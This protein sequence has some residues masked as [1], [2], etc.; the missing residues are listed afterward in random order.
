MVKACITA[1]SDVYWCSIKGSVV[2]V[3]RLQTKPLRAAF[4]PSP[5]PGH[6][7]APPDFVGEGMTHVSKSQSLGSWKALL[8]DPHLSL[9]FGRPGRLH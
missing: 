7:R 4:S 9:K 2:F 3:L 8:H 1:R 5:E 6:N